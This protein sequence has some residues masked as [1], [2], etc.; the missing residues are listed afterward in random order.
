[1]KISLF[2]A[3]L[4]EFTMEEIAQTASSLG[5]NGLEL[6][7]CDM[8]EKMKA[9]GVS[10]WGE[11]KNDIGI[12]NFREKVPGIKRVCEKYKLEIPLLATYCMTF[13]RDQIEEVAKSMGLLGVKAFRVRPP[14]FMRAENPD[15]DFRK[16][17]K[18]TEKDME[19]IVKIC[20]KHDLRACV[21]THMNSIAPSAALVMKII[22]RFD[23]K[24]VGAIYDPGNTMQEGSENLRLSIQMLGKYLAH[25]HVKNTKWTEQEKK[26]DGTRVFKPEMA[27]L[28]EGFLDLKQVFDEL[29]LAGYNGWLSVE[30]FTVKADKK[31]CLKEDI[32][33]MRRLWN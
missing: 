28:N 2:T 27:K 7:V 14:W 16:L 25:V 20:E 31:A 24:Y 15:P 9:S 23:P 1:M 19:F 6:R 26:K 32:N 29:K 5:Y 10:F 4:P 13:E 18:E 17:S 11:H 3:L 8:T 30:D 21:E 22:D 12:K 33:Y